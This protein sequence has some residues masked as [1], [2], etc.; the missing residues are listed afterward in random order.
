M[1]RSFGLF[2]LLVLL[3]GTSVWSAE[4][5]IEVNDTGSPSDDYLCWSPTHARIK[6]GTE[7][8]SAVAV[9]ISQ[10]NVPGGG[11]IWFLRDDGARPTSATFDPQETLA[12]TLPADGSWQSFWVAGRSPSVANQDVS[13]I[14]TTSDGNE[15]GRAPVMVRVRKNADTLTP[16]ERDQFLSALRALHDLDHDARVSQYIKYYRAH[17]DAFDLGIHGAPDGLPLFL[18][19]HR[20]FLLSIERELQLIDPTVALPYWRFDRPSTK[21]FSRDFMGTVQRNTPGPGGF[22]V[23]F[24]PT[25]SLRGWSM[26]D[27]QGALVR[28]RD[29]DTRPPIPAGR[30]DDLFNQPRASAYGGPAGGLNGALEFSYHNG[31]HSVISGWL[32]TGSSPRD[33][34]FYLLHANVDRAWALWQDQHKAFDFS[35]TDGKSYT[36]SAQGTYPGPQPPDQFRKGSYANDI[37]WPWSNVGGDGGTPDEVDDW[38]T[39]A[40][41]MPNGLP[42]SGPTL[43]PT[44]ASQIDYLDTHGRGLALNACYDDIPYRAD[45]SAP[46]PVNP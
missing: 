13:I 46:G 15:I 45:A 32:A 1:K 19:W 10:R 20:A 29:G 42:N 28:G 17:D 30:L 27:G 22:I 40:F 8:D 24:S 11:T 9:T 34:L 4:A 44:P 33:P 12:V 39:I 14:A 37:M 36:A 3:S 16:A 25:N 5:I 18:S 38:P 21:I 31:A 6:L 41:P 35:A 7:T 43:P 2:C 26:H 23:E